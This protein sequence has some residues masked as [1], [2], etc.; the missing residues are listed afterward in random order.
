MWLNIFLHRWDNTRCAIKNLGSLFN[1]WKTCWV[2]RCH[3]HFC[4]PF[5]W[6]L[7]ECLLPRQFGNNVCWSYLT[8]CWNIQSTQTV[9]KEKA[10]QFRIMQEIIYPL[11]FE[12]FLCRA[13]KSSKEFHFRARIFVFMM[14]SFKEVVWVPTGRFL[15][16]Y[17]VYGISKWVNSWIPHK[18][19]RNCMFNIHFTY[20]PYWFSNSQKTICYL[21]IKGWPSTWIS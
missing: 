20:Q 16:A 18:N 12:T 13:N 14:I 5:C 17:S 6:A 3:K 11:H 2:F 1:I 10:M 19:E 21:S 8:D 7:V 9:Q 4:D 15:Q